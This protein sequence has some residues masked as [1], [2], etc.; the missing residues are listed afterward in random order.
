MISATLLLAH[1]LR[2]QVIAEGL[3]SD[4]DVAAL[5]DMG[6]EYGQGFRIAGPLDAHGLRRWITT[7]AAATATAARGGGA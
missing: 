2:Q 3:E 5:R 4:E 6:C 1:D 7:R